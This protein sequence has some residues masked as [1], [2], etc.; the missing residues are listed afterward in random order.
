MVAHHLDTVTPRRRTACRS[1]KRDLP[2]GPPD[3]TPL[4]H[5]LFEAALLE[6]PPASLRALA[7]SAGI[8]FWRL[9][10]DLATPETTTQL[11]NEACALLRL[12]GILLS[13]R[14]LRTATESGDPS[15][16]KIALSVIPPAPA[17]AHPSSP[18]MTWTDLLAAIPPASGP[19]EHTGA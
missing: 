17:T 5:R 12:L 7:E 18:L 10:R 13:I 14:L 3:A 16:A 4:W 15:L 1:R 8:P 11:E 9:L 6:D 2:D 19:E